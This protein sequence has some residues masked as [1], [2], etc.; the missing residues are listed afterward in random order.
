MRENVMGL[1]VVT[2]DGRI[3]KTGGRAR[4]SS[5]GYDL[6]RLFVGAEGTLGIITESSCACMAYRKRFPRRCASSTRSKGRCRP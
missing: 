4:K 6:T 2:A 5:A 1:T 3:I